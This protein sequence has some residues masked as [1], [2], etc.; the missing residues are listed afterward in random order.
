MPVRELFQRLQ[1]A[2]TVEEV[3]TALASLEESV[4]ESR[5][6]WYPVGGRENNRGVIEMSADPGR[7][8]VERITNAVDAI[9]E[10]EFE[11]H[12]G[13]PESASPREAA[14]AWLNVPE[15]GLSAMTP[16]QRQ[17]LAERCVVRLF[18]GEG[19]ESR[20]VEVRDHGIG[21]TPAQLPLTILSLNEN[22]KMQKHYLAGAYGQGGSSTFA[23]SKYVFIASRQR[24]SP[25]VGFSVVRF[26]DLPPETFKIGRYAYLTVDGAVLEVELSETEFPPGTLVRHFGYDLSK[27]S[28]PLGPNSL[29]G[30]FNEVMFDPIVPI[31]L[32]SILHGY[33][34]VIKGSRNALNGAV[35]EGDDDRRGPKLA[36]NVPLYFV[37]LSDFGRIGIEY[38][39]LDTQ[40]KERKR[41]NAAF[42]NPSRP[43]V[44][45]L[46][47]QN[48]A[49]LSQSLVRKPAD[50]PFLSQRLI[51]HVDCNHL[52]PQ[53]KRALFVSTREDARKGRISEMIEEELVKALRSDDKLTQ[54]NAEARDEMQKGKDEAASETI[55]REVS[56]L[57][58]LQGVSV[59]EIDAERRPGDRPG[60]KPSGAK[61]SPRP[62]PQAIDTQEPPTFVR[63]VWAGEDLTFYPGQRRYVRI[64][65]DAGSSYH[66]ANDPRMSRINVIVTGISLN[67]CGSTPL[68][69]GR[70]RVVQEA[71]DR[72]EVGSSGCIR[73]ELSRVG[74]SSLS[75]E[76][77]VRVVQKPPARPASSKS[78]LPPFK[79]QS[80]DG[81][82]SALW[83]NLD[84]PDYISTV[85]SS[86][87]MEEGTLVIYYS[88]VFPNF[89]KHRSSFEQKNP[90]SGTSFVER[91]KIW[92]AVHSL[93]AYQ[94][95]QAR[96]SSENETDIDPEVEERLDRQERC[97]VATMSALIASREMRADATTAEAAE[98]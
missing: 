47:G 74:L 70:M 23:A 61:P 60:Q 90:Q 85:A 7:S 34:R 28:S 19:R 11:R 91:Y 40:E 62:K 5:L 27:Y 10:A 45:T 17:K 43:I 92:L 75:D 57:L 87:R 12:H 16:G 98:E 1:N 54:L 83:I 79:F 56:R 32:D 37:K 42:V 68:K 71:P 36:H 55:K 38:W 52:T 95:Q 24:R 69:D 82:E 20:L 64:E 21:V 3:R 6:T 89:E 41:P 59:G 86:S 72:L 84:W 4:G 96:E 30:L 67:D 25:S 35:D 66:N 73:V 22:N 53:A 65:T 46:N 49:E 29:Y 50:L 39:V 76:R 9:L 58:K 51:V 8:I 97:R 15:D 2:N 33:R 88:T 31:W 18:P 48:Q 81:P 13:L 63:I 80:V 77:V 44:L 14:V 93:L 78:T 26:H 94:D